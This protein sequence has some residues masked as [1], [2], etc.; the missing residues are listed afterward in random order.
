[1]EKACPHLNQYSSGKMKQKMKLLLLKCSLIV[2][3]KKNKEKV[4]IT[5]ICFYGYAK[6]EQNIKVCVME[7]KGSVA[8]MIEMR[9]NN[10]MLTSKLHILL[11]I[12]TPC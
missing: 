12:L 2:Q 1:M 5:K 11:N 4:I 8:K 3:T 9:G 10:P 6:I 7:N